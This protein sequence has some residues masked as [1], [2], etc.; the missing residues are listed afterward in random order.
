V[1]RGSAIQELD[2]PDSA[3]SRYKNDNAEVVVAAIVC[4]MQVSA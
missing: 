4:D 2:A 3:R 1:S